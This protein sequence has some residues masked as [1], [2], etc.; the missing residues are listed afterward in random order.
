M[1]NILESIK[2]GDQQIWFVIL[3]TLSQSEES[4]SVHIFSIR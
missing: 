3:N 2:I 4:K 1:K